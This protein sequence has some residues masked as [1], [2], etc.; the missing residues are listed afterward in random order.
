MKNHLISMP[1]L[2]LCSTGKDKSI[3]SRQ[4][5]PFFGITPNRVTWRFG[6]GGTCVGPKTNFLIEVLVNHGRMG[7]LRQQQISI[8]I[9]AVG[10]QGKT[11]R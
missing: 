9:G 10:S 4:A 11:Q 5:F 3:I 1:S 6:S 2:T 7:N 8:Y